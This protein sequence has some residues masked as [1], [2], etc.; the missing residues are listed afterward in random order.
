MFNSSFT[1]FR[2]MSLFLSNPGKNEFKH[3]LEGEE[4]FPLVAMGGKRLHR[5]D[6]LSKDSRAA[7]CRVVL[8]CFVLFFNAGC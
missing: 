4:C 3:D 8:F 7:V 2:I 1:I 5:G 6:S